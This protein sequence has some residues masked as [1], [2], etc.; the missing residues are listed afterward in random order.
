MHASCV[1]WFMNANKIKKSLN[2]LGTFKKIIVWR[3]F[4]AD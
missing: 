3:Y 2:A 4:N 1:D